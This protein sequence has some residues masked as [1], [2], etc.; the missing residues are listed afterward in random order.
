MFIVFP[1]LLLNIQGCATTEDV[2]GPSGEKLTLIDCSGEYLNW[3]YCQAE[4]GKICG[5]KGYDVVQQDTDSG[6]GSASISGNSNTGIFGTATSIVTRTMMV[7]CK[8]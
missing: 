4:A 8:D 2:Y 7:R 1:F 3:G 6:G 5:E